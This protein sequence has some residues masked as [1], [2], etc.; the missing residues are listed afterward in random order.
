[1][2]P[3]LSTESGANTAVT[4]DATRQWV[5]MGWFLTFLLSLQGRTYTVLRLFLMPSDSLSS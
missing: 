2:Q 5:P 1:M 4:A 3:P